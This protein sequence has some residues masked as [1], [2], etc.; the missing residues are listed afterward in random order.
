ML[1]S[2]EC[3]W[4]LSHV[5]LKFGEWT[6]K[7]IGHLYFSASSFVHH[8]KAISKLQLKL[9]SENSQFRSESPIFCPVWP[10]NLTDDLET[11]QGTF[12]MLLEV[13]Y[14]IL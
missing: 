1:I 14:I 4:F 7:T 9:Q 13:L 12:S 6:W 10:W 8:F 2:G 5:T 3:R 11:Q